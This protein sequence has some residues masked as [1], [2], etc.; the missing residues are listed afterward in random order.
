MFQPEIIIPLESLGAIL[1]TVRSETVDDL[2]KSSEPN[3]LSRW[4]STKLLP[5]FSLVA[6]HPSIKTHSINFFNLG[7][8]PIGVF[9]R[10]LVLQYPIVKMKVAI[11]LLLLVVAQVHCLSGSN[12]GGDG[13][14]PRGT[15]SNNQPQ[16]GAQGSSTGPH[17]ADTLDNRLERGGQHSADSDSPHNG[18]NN[19]PYSPPKLNEDEQDLFDDF[20]LDLAMEGLP[21][22]EEVAQA[23]GGGEEEPLPLHDQS[24]AGQPGANQHS[25]NQYPQQQNIQEQ[26]QNN[27][28]QSQQL[29]GQS[30]PGGLGTSS[31]IGSGTKMYGGA[32]LSK[33]DKEYIFEGLRRLYTRKVLPLEEASKYSHFG[34]PPMSPSDF[35]AKPMVLIIGQYSVGKTSFIR[36]LVGVRA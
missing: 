10:I 23:F 6:N 17:P 36:S 7:L 11:C 29:S 1:A 30:T 26:Q 35:E 3:L 22:P 14:Y 18:N 27:L 19:A 4:L 25:Q 5:V 8:T 20:D 2:V 13:F 32:N 28:Q 31:S 12:G 15:N 34:S 9:H 16:T 21:S 24:Q 33:A